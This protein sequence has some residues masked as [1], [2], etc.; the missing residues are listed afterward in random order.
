[1]GLIY[2]DWAHLF[3]LNPEHS[4]LNHSM[5]AEYDVNEGGN[6]RD[7]NFAIVIHIGNGFI[8]I[9]DAQDHIDEGCYITHIYPTIAVHITRNQRRLQIVHNINEILPLL[10][11]TILIITAFKHMQCAFG[12]FHTLKRHQ[13]HINRMIDIAVNVI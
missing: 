9:S 3:Y 4:T 8:F 6:I 1:M 11:I 2:T 12:H 13:I 7:I 10:C 5:N